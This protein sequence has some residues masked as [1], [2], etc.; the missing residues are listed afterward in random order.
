[1]AKKVAGKVRDKWK[2]K[3]WL[4]VLASPSFGSAPIVRIP[5]TDAEKARG[6]VVETT[7]YD[8]LKQDPQHYSFKLY[9]QVDRVEGETAHT[10]LRGHE[11]SREYLRSL[12]RRGSSM[13]D[14]IKDYRT[15]DGYLV[16]VYC[17]A[18]SQG[19]MN[20]SKKHDLRSVMDRVIGER[21]S[22]LTYDQFAQ[23]MVLQKIASDV[24]NEAKKVTHLRHVGLRKSKL[25]RMPEGSQPKPQEAV[26]AAA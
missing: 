6:R 23:E 16:R 3:S 21:A 8:I 15:K 9:F 11:Y 17:I 19:R 7:L 10:V 5:V 12:V 22:S 20:T 25:I 18:F 1:M 14:L 4:T 13:S 2:L 26:L 24:Y